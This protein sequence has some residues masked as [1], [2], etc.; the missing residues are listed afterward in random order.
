MM[1]GTLNPAAFP[2]ISA[3]AAPPDFGDMRTVPPAEY[4]V[5]SPHLLLSLA[6]AGWP[7][8]STNAMEPD[9]RNRTTE[10][11]QAS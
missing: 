11:A 5:Q 6:C 8:N 10:I 2:S 7:L 4:Q 9:H 1:S 3:K